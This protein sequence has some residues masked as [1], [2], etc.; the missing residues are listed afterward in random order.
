MTSAYDYTDAAQVHRVQNPFTGEIYFTMAIGER[1]FLVGLGWRDRGTMGF[2]RTYPQTTP[3][4]TITAPATDPARFRTVWHLYHPA[5]GDRV[6]TARMAERLFVRDILGFQE[7]A[8][9]GFAWFSILA[10]ISVMVES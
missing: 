1:D 4:F 3:P 7:H 9:R 5:T 2:M 10:D 8:P 6:M